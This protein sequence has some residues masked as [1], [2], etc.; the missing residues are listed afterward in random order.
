MRNIRKTPSS[1]AVTVDVGEGPSRRTG[2]IVN[3]VSQAVKALE[4]L[5]TISPVECR[6]SATERFNIETTTHNFKL[7]YSKVLKKSAHNSSIWR[8]I[9][10]KLPGSIASPEK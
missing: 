2:F 5:E 6:K 4:K 8:Q 1:A 10:P 3:N 7:L 9:D